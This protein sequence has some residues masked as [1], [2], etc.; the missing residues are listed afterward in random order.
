MYGEWVEVMES[1]WQRVNY[2]KVDIKGN[3]KRG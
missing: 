3:Q 2:G 1:E